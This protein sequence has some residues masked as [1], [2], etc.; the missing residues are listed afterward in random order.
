MDIYLTVGPLL[1][2]FQGT[3]P[4]VLII[5][6]AIG[7]GLGLACQIVFFPSSTSHVALDGFEKLVRILKTPLDLTLASICDGHQPQ[8]QDLQKLKSGTLALYKSVLPALG[9]VQL[10]FSVSRWNAD[11]VKSLKAPLREAS[12]RTLSLL[13]S[14]IARIGG[15][16]KADKL[17]ALTFDSDSFSS[18]ALDEKKKPREAGLRQLIESAGMVNAMRSSEHEGFHKEMLDAVREPISTILPVCQDAVVV[19]ADSIKAVNSAR[20]FNRPSKQRFDELEENA[21]STLEKLKSERAAFAINT[22]DRLIQIN[23]DLFDENGILKDLEENSVYRMRAISMAMVIE[24]QIIAVAAS[25]ER[26]LDHLLALMNDRKS[27]RLWYP[28]GLGYAIN[29]VFR[30]SAVAPVRA[31]EVSV[32]DPEELERK[33]KAA[34]QSLRM[35]RGY[36]TRRRNG[37]G[38]IIL[39]VYHWLINSEGMYALRVVGVTIALGIPAVI[40]SSAGFYYR[41]KGLWALIMG[42]TTVLVYMSDFTLSLVSRTNGTIIGGVLGLVAW[43]IGSGDGPG[44][45]YGMAAV[46][47]VIIAI[48]MWLRIFA[49]PVLLQA[50]IMGC[51]TCMLIVGYSFDYHWNPQYGN[52][53]VGYTV[54]WRRLLL[55][56]IG[57]AAAVIL[58]L[59]PRPPSATR[60]VCKSLSGVIRALTDH[61][62]LLLSCWGKPDR[63]E[64]LVAEDLAFNLA[65]SL[66]ALDGPIAVL[67]VEFSG[68]QFDSERL[69]QIKSLCQDLNQHLARLL[70]LSAS[71]PE[72]FQSHLAQ[73]AGMLDHRH[74]GDVMAVL[75]VVDQA[76][77]T[78]DPLP[79]VLP[80]PLLKRCLE[81]WSTHRA[82]VSLSK[83]LLRDEEYRR[84]CV[85]VSSYLRFLGTVDDL[86]LV[87]KGTVGES[88]IVS[89]ELMHDLL[90]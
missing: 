38:R 52:P 89:R 23:E 71:L 77:K 12:L 76:L 75:N 61:Y 51:A 30:K 57:F 35:S 15:K 6:A 43:Y 45:S 42:Q 63:E 16:E 7:I 85:A 19:T 9:F 62:A 64:G 90:V 41:E 24:D 46:M 18:V 20:W 87:M 5:P 8:I 84:F 14:H 3:I 48:M 27:T 70:N 65:E 59:L 29:W 47:A 28:R 83:D 49:P 68:S 53:G 79:E 21:R 34:Q 40:P 33:T 32:D 54:F 72:R 66:S 86:V 36:R 73:R 44:N 80:T 10:D 4:R 26:V 17:R 1:P 50:V 82:D 13:E 25:W 22:P 58:Q 78:G 88:H 81:F 56:I 74:I 60:H 67:K 39:S 37:L 55:V 69:G 11:D 2:A 31:A